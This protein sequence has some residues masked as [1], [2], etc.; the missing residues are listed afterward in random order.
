M[1]P[2]YIKIKQILIK[3]FFNQGFKYKYNFV[4]SSTLIRYF[5]CQNL[6]S[7]Q[8]NIKESVIL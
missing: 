1:S 5:R 2:F 4:D 7:L 8:I 3:Y 6:H